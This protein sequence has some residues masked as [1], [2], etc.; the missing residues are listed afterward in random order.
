MIVGICS[1]ELRLAENH[2]LKGKRRVLKSVKD[3]VRGRF[4]VSIAEIS[5]L[6]SW[7]RSTIGVACVSKDRDQVESTLAHVATFV[8]AL[9]LASVEN[10]HTEIL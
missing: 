7:Q 5:D 8:E 4:N 6:D 10:V 1:I 3:R 9:G 2:D